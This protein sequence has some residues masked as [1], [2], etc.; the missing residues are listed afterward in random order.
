MEDLYIE[1]YQPTED[2]LLQMPPVCDGC[3]KEIALG[4]EPTFAVGTLNGM[5]PMC[6]KCA[7][8]VY[9]SWPGTKHDRREDAEKL[10]TAVLEIAVM[11]KKAKSARAEADA[12]DE[13]IRL[14]P[15]ISR[16]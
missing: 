5:T 16:R 12:L 1:P 13:L 4:E 14:I 2:E 7:E 15:R 6:A 8:R 11:G 9:R 3:T 10:L